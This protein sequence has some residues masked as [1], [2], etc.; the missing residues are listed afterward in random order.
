ME[1]RTNLYDYIVDTFGLKN[2]VFCFPCGH[3]RTYNRTTPAILEAL[4]C[5]S[6]FNTIRETTGLTKFNKYQLHRY[7]TVDLYPRK[8]AC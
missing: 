4:G 8:E 6:S 3:T 7:D 5:H 1:H 2:P